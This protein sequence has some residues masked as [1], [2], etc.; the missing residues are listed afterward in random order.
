V[1]AYGVPTIQARENTLT[2][3]I[4]ANK[5]SKKEKLEPGFGRIFLL[6]YHGGGWS[7]RISMKSK[8][9]RAT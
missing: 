7:R 9:S 3:K 8:P 5:S 2:H 4:K 6:S 1:H